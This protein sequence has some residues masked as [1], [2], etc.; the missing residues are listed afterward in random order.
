M[1]TCACAKA[2]SDNTD[3][4]NFGPDSTGLTI[5]ANYAIQSGGKV[6]VNT[7]WKG[8]KDIECYA[9]WIDASGHVYQNMRF[10][11]PDGGCTIDVPAES[12]LYLLYVQT[13]K[14]SRSF[15]FIIQ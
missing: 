7:D 3:K 6:F 12:G 2:F 1:K 15:K 9:Q 11:V 14:G 10:D 8:E 13:G 4:H 5:T